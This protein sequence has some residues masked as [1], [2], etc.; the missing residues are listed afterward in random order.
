V[1]NEPAND[2]I[3]DCCSGA[4]VG[5]AG[6]T[7]AGTTLSRAFVGSLNSNVEKASDHSALEFV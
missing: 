6:I 2:I 5:R 7:A 3:L 1:N 4:S